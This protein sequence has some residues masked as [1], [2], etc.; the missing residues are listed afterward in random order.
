MANRVLLGKISGSTF[1]LKVSKKGQ[2]VLTAGNN[3]LLFDSTLN[4]TG[5]I[6]AGGNGINF[7]GQSGNPTENAGI[8]FLTMVSPNKTNL[9][10]IP[11]VLRTEKNMGE[12]DDLVNFT[13]SID[14]ISVWETTSTSFIPSEANANDFAEQSP[15]ANF[16]QPAPSSGRSTVIEIPASKEDAINVSF[17]VLRIPCAFGYMNSSYFGS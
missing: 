5:Q 13:Y 14:Q 4:R 6:Y 9:G 8:N 17:F 12:R 3:Q 10:Y 16:T 7:D 1:G 2:N 15:V 11:L